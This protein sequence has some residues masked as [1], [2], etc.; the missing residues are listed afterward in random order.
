MQDETAMKQIV[1]NWPKFDPWNKTE[2]TSLSTSSRLIGFSYFCAKHKKVRGAEQYSICGKTRGGQQCIL[3][4]FEYLL[5]G[6]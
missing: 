5:G 4:I 6:Q 2:M 1:I 3:T